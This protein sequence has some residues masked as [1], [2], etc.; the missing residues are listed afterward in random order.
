MSDKMPDRMPENICVRQCDLNAGKRTRQS[1]NAGKHVKQYAFLCARLVQY[2]IG[3]AFERSQFY[4]FFISSFSSLSSTNSPVSAQKSPRSLAT[5]S[6]KSTASK[7][8]HRWEVLT[9]SVIL[10]EGEGWYCKDGGNFDRLVIWLLLIYKCWKKNWLEIFVIWSLCSTSV[11]PSTSS[12]LKL[13]CVKDRLS[14]CT[15]SNNMKHW[16]PCGKIDSTTHRC[17]AY[18]WMWHIDIWSCHRLLC[19]QTIRSVWKPHGDQKWDQEE[20]PKH[21][22]KHWKNSTSQTV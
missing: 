20:P 10:K 9:D 21:S 15:K 18:I 12:W 22:G 7:R 2:I 17:T 16:Y 3:R 4:I 6:A 14:M 11:S 19:I 1:R 13:D 8:L 5:G